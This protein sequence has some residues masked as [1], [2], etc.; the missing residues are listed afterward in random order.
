ME[1]NHAIKPAP[2]GSA[3][4]LTSDLDSE[5]IDFRVLRVKEESVFIE[6]DSEVGGFGHLRN[7]S[8]EE[9]DWSAPRKFPGVRWRHLK[10][11][12]VVEQQV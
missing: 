11:P 3:G 6:G 10:T 2:E 1:A 5:A 4:G 7:P 9:T 8:G 12:K